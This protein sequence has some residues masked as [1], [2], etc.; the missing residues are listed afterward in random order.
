MEVVVENGHQRFTQSG[1]SYY[2]FLPRLAERIGCKN[3]LEIGVRSGRS[4]RGIQAATVGV[5]PALQI[6]GD[7]VG[8]KPCLLLFQM[9]SDEF[10]SRYDLRQL[11][12][13]PV[14]LAFLDGMHLFEFLLRDFTNTELWATET[15]TILLHDCFPINAEMTER[16]RGS[17]RR[18]DAE[19]RAHW[20]GDVW[21][22]MRILKEYRPDLQVTCLNCSPTGLAVVTRLDPKSTVL[23]DHYDDIVREYMDVVM[24]DDSIADHFAEFSSTEADEYLERLGS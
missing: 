16:E 2:D 14:D 6:R 10:F 19:L 11:L 4:L 22:M 1:M 15:S 24:T 17:V 12:Q 5:D 7:T 13:G 21:K 18:R 23:R 8:S 9:T 20:T 3:Y